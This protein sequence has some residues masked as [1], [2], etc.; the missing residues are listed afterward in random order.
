[1]FGP[2][3]LIRR[4]LWLC[5]VALLTAGGTLRADENEVRP[6]KS[7]TGAVLRSLVVPGWGQFYNESY[8]KAAAF[9]VIE[10]T[11]I[12]SASHQHD[13]MMRFKT[14]GDFFRERF[15]RN[16][17]NKLLWWLTGVV[18]LSMGDAYVDAHLYHLDVSPDLSSDGKTIGITLTRTFS[19]E[20]LL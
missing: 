19:L 4:V 15:Y 16:N 7:T 11:L 17:R 1:M 2:D 14:G 5:L 12:Y 3:R 8:I 6:L 20:Q 13:E 10:G 9:A 18:L